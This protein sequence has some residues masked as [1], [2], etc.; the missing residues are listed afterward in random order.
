MHPGADVHEA[1]GTFEMS[2]SGKVAIRLRDIDGQESSETYTF[3]LTLL[4]DERPFIRILE[5][6]ADALAT[7]DASVPVLLSAEDD[8]GLARVQLFRSLNDSRPRPADVAVPTPSPSRW[9]E[10]AILPLGECGVAPG[11]VIKVFARVEDNDPDGAKGAESTFV[12]I[13]I[14]AQADF[15]RLMRTREGLEVLTARYDMAN[16]RLEALLEAIEQLE[17]ELAES[18]PES[19]ASREQRERLGKLAQQAADA[20]RDVSEAA[21]KTLPYDLDRKLSPELQK[22]A[23]QMK[24][25]AD[26]A[27]K[28]SQSRGAS[29]SALGKKLAELARK[30]G[31]QRKEF[32]EKALE[33]IR[34][35]AAVFPLLEDQALFI[36]V[37][38]RQRDLA[39]RLASLRGR[40]DI[41]DPAVKVR[42]RDLEEEQRHLRDALGE[43]L[44]RIDAHVAT[45]PEDAELDELRETAS[46]FS[47]AVRE[48][49]ALD[50]M[51]SAEAGLAEFS[52]T[53]AHQ[54]AKKAAEI[55][56][57][58]IGQCNGMGSCAS[59]CMKFQPTLSSNMGNTVEQLLS[60]LGLSAGMAPGGG[61]GGGGGYSM[62]R[63][64]LQNVGMYGN[65]PT[66]GT[67]TPGGRSGDQ[68]ATAG[69]GSGPGVR[70]ESDPR[71]DT[72]DRGGQAVGA[73][74]IDVPLQYRQKVGRYFERIA[75]EIGDE[76]RAERS[77][78][79]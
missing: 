15:E 79:R 74:N 59:S 70:H 50:A 9:Q 48:S 12:T 32:N 5:P 25:A 35:L 34:H 1:V 58:F 10:T 67:P 17:K 69:R 57:K 18:P 27:R 36:G 54:G 76:R 26:E 66:R 45:L 13:R 16:R 49:E 41:D 23:E 31:G 71:A 62:Q 4:R 64:S 65:L 14:I 78:G 20:A 8:H 61:I 75:D 22:I 72:G 38:Q 52:G 68:A 60:D 37:Y 39:E 2:T 28:L 11:D 40:D 6:P 47:K 43:L 77:R 21:R 55:L 30:L 19:E 7:P 42:M 63:S 51:S 46:K 56:E 24:A 3:P 33:P 73:A 44:D 29:V 53:L